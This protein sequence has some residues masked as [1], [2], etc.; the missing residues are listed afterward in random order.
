M[1]PIR[2][3]AL[4]LV[5]GVV[6]QSTAAAEGLPDWENPR[7]VGINKQAPHALVVPYPD[8][9]KAATLEP[10]SS[11]WYR[12]L[13]GRWKFR[14]SP[15]PEARPLDFH[16]T[17]FDDS[18]WGE[19]PVPSNMEIEGHGV[20]IYVN[21]GYAWGR[22]T[23]PRVPHEQNSVGS[24]RHR[25]E[26]PEFWRGRRVMITF[27]GV[28][29]AFYLWV[30]GRKVG[31]SQESRTPAEFDITD[32]VRTGENLLAVEVYRYSDGSYLEC[33]DF[34][35]LSGIYRDVAI[36]SVEP[37]HVRDF[38]VVTDLDDRYR[39]ARLSVS[40]DVRNVSSEEQAFSLQAALLDAEGRQSALTLMTRGRVS[41]GAAETASLEAVVENP[42]KWSDEKPHLYTL[43][44]TLKDDSGRAL[45]VVPSR[46]G[47]REVE[48]HD[49]KILVNGQPILIRG[50]NRHEH[51]P[52]TGHV[53][54]RERMIED[55]RIMKQNNFNLVRTSH[56]PNVRE[57]YDL[58]DEYGLYVISEANIESHG[59]GYAPDR[60]LGNNPEWKVAHLDRVERMVEAFKNHPSIIMWSLG[61][62]AGDGVNFVAS[63]DWVHDHEPT[64]PVHY[65]LAGSGPHVD[66]VS[67]M[68]QKVWDMES[69][70]REPDPRPLILCEYS[71][72]MGNSNGNFDEYWDL[73]RSGGRARGGA[74]WDFVDQGLLRPVPARQ[75]V[76][77]R[78]ESSLEGIFVGENDPEKGAEGFVVLPDAE[79]LDL[80]DALT[81]EAEL[82]PVPVIK[83]AVSTARFNPFV[84][85]GSLGYTLRQDDEELQLSLALE[86]RIRP[87]VLRALVPD[88]W[89]DEWHRLTGTY[90]GTT[91]RLFV[92]GALVASA[93]MAGRPSPGHFPVNVGRNPESV[94]RLTPTRFREVRVYS[95]ALTEEEIEDPA[96]RTG[97][98]LVL[99]LRADDI[100]QVGRA[101]GG[102]FF[103]YGGAFG[104]ANTPSDENFCMNGV[105][106]ADRTP[107]PAL[108]VI[109][110]VQRYI[111]VSP[112][113]LLR[114]RIPPDSLVDLPG[115]STLPRPPPAIES[116][117]AIHNEH[118]FTNLDEIAVG[119]WELRGDD[120]LLGEGSLG[121]LDVAPQATRELAIDLPTITPEPGV[122]YWLDLVFL[123]KS[124]TAWARTGH[125][126]AHEQLALP[127]RA[128]RA[129]LL[130]GSLPPLTV[131]GGASAIEVRG[132]DFSA[133]VDPATGLL[134]SLQRNGVEILAGPLHPHFW[135]APID[136]DRGNDMPQGSGVWRDAH[137]FL[138]PRSIRTERPSEGVVRIQVDGDLTSVG[139]SCE[140]A[141]T[142]YGSG[143][144]LVEVSLE[145]GET[146]LPELPR[147]GMQARIR[148]GF[149]HLEWYGPGPEETYVD[150]RDLP[151][152]VYRT[153]V[154]ANYF[155]YSQPQETGNKVD[156]RWAALTSDEGLGLLAVGDPV[157]G[158]NALHYA[159]ED[160]DQALYRHQ[161]TRRDEVYLNLDWRQ[162][163]VGGDDSWGALPH[164]EYRLSAQ[165]YSYR[166]RLRAFDPATESPMELSR[167]D[168]P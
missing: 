151:V 3:L 130:S 50:V 71:H 88:D 60:T 161:L 96:D 41:P 114:N 42:A 44:L 43:L 134:S 21:T 141:Y 8:A 95:R 119:R 133:A 34:W 17:G 113:H 137:R 35:R 144:I 165:P 48:I 153:T 14:W 126:L 97:D 138:T 122:E 135:R 18:A 104:P 131:V 156:V 163:G 79:P 54:S 46:V 57:W 53:L 157:L 116:V 118:R 146:R 62:E 168:M 51:D 167:V 132:P 1:I 101:P 121:T 10:G 24:Y 154:D 20:P 103:A 23:P 47:F 87:L 33:Q 105:V 93:E 139:A 124:D 164:E 39:D 110:H 112:V 120:R 80:R 107:H 45:G 109:S 91:A 9:A 89:Y 26:V 16:E 142:V 83:G 69:E 147:F 145:P 99:W 59:M 108:A 75:V 74:I 70:A 68:Y 5:V 123:L 149:E 37:L 85:K 27:D 140:L 129:R 143:D 38:T 7:I 32:F 78:S 125:V 63:S 72:A 94:D 82:L 155:E 73:F 49:G 90:D 55:I 166:F 150:R 65:E 76:R 148:P 158:V 15:R 6:P 58:C 84:S 81:L 22:G 56:Y 127:V 92:D 12:R 136:N 11:R 13:N 31:Y 52:E 64:R 106:S 128:P 4:S 86:G 19:I 29:S 25:F 2:S 40:V 111:H 159:A 152:G 66:V 100:E 162:R 160:L 61:N 102:H 67:H 98:G 117:V 28:S 36:W 77:D 115:S 30:N